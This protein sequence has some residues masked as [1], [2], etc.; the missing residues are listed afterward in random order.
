[1]KK[2]EPKL[3]K[4]DKVEIQGDCTEDVLIWAQLFV[5]QE[6]VV[7]DV[8]REEKTSSSSINEIGRLRKSSEHSN[9]TGRN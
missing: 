1:M 8:A 7:D 4:I 2:R 5:D 6:G 9:K 3:T